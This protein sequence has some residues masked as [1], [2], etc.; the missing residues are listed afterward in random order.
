MRWLEGITDSVDMILS[1]LQI[2]KDRE[3]SYA[4]VH[5]AAKGQTPLSRKSSVQFSTL[6]LKIPLAWCK[7]NPPLPSL[8]IPCFLLVL[9]PG[10]LF[11]H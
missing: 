9:P 1:K 7:N 2:V 4:A 6:S 10:V 3:A 5:G 11:S 8:V